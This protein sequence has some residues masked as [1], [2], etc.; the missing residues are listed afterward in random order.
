MRHARVRALRLMIHGPFPV[1][2]RRVEGP[3]VVVTGFLEDRDNI[4]RRAVH[5][6]EL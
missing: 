1:G 6:G 3:A 2:H 4:V 5:S